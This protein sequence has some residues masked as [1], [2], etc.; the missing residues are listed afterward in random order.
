MADTQKNIKVLYDHT[1]FYYQNYG[2][3]SRYFAGLM[4]YMKSVDF[5]F[6]AVYSENKYLKDIPDIKVRNFL[7]FSKIGR[8][9]GEIINRIYL[10]FLFTASKYD[11]FH[12][13]DSKVCFYSFQ[14]KPIVV[15]IHDMIFELMG[16]DGFP[17]CPQKFVRETIDNKKKLIE[18]SDHIITISHNTKN[19]ILKIYPNIPESKITVI[20]HGCVIGETLSEGVSDPLIKHPY[21]LYV[22]ARN[23]YK[24]FKGMLKAIAS[25]LRQSS[26]LKL[27]CTGKPF[28]DEEKNLINALKIE[29]SVLNILA[30]DKTMCNLYSNAQLFIFPSLYEGFG[31]PLLEAFFFGVP[32]CISNASCFPEIAYDAAVYFDPYDE[33]D[34]RNAVEKVLGDFEL[35]ERLISK[36]K[37]RLK[38]FSIEKMVQQTESVYKSVLE[39]ENI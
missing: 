19:D 2:G 9:F 25:L 22:G 27:V 21:I 6:S 20:Y 13:T 31:F 36:G 23:G 7:P 3:V 30:N 34:I 14:R 11:I 1:V 18:N 32:A 8:Y 39:Y 35:K 10:L 28:D 26:D 4:K 12:P 38:F 37:E 24:N 15:T 16:E 5:L 29:K 33:V 17:K